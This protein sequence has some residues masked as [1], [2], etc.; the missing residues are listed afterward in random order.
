MQFYKTI[1]LLL[2]RN[3]VRDEVV[4]ENADHWTGS[5]TLGLE[6]EHPFRLYVFPLRKISPLIH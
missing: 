2:I 4:S 3:S 1:V 5:S 6:L